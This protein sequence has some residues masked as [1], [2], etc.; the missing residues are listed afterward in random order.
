MITATLTKGSTQLGLAHNFRV[1]VLYHH[2][3]RH[4]GT[5]ADIVLDRHF[6][7]RISKQQKERDTGPGLGF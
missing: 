5:Q 3:G 1:L 4:A 2:S 7:I 6:Y